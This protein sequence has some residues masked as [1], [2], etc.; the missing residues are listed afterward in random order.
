MSNAF[1]NYEKTTHTS[2]EGM[3]LKGRKILRLK[4]SFGLKAYRAIEKVVVFHEI[5]NTRYELLK[6]F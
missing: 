2:K 5:E 6:I 3:E 4:E 1:D